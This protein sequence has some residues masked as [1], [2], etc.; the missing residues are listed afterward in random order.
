ML[1][2]LL[3]RASIVSQITAQKQH[4]IR[5]LTQDNHVPANLGNY[6]YVRARYI[7]VRAI[8]H[9]FVH[10]CVHAC[11]YSLSDKIKR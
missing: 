4:Q 5:Q 11:M 6:A 3:S 9:T 10:V 1:S 7:S 2:T 8:V